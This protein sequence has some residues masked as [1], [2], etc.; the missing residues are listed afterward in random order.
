VRDLGAAV[1]ASSTVVYTLFGGRDELL[2]AVF[3]DAV[4]QLY[5]AM[6]SVETDDPMRYLVETAHAYRRFAIAN[7]HMYAIL[8]ATE[9]RIAAGALRRSRAMQLLVGGVTRCLERGVFTAGDPHKIA[10]VMWAMLHGIVSLE[11]AGYFPDEKTATE[12]FMLAGFQMFS[13]FMPRR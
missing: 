2:I 10:D 7:P 12:R 3:E 13:S 4:D 5:L 1:G 6:A 9:P 11:L 8:L